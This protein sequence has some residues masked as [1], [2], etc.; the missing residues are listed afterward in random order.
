VN[1]LKVEK[2][3]AHLQ[4]QEMAD[5]RLDRIIYLL[6]EF[7]QKANGAKVPLLVVLCPELQSLRG[8]ELTAV[9]KKIAKVASDHK[10]TMCMLGD[11]LVP[12]DSCAEGCPVDLFFDDRRE[13]GYH[14]QT[15][16]DLIGLHVGQLFIET[17][18]DDD[19]FQLLDDFELLVEEALEEGG[20]QLGQQFRLGLPC[21][22]EG[23]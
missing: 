10:H 18:H 16:T 5:C 21:Q 14:L 20:L 12:L 7:V 9:L 13:S 3:L 22:V 6:A 8:D 2:G 23:H 17:K 4:V 19:L 1:H 15:E 11:K